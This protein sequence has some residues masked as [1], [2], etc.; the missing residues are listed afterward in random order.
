MSSYIYIINFLLIINFIYSQDWMMTITADDIDNIGAADLIY[1][2][3][4][5]TCYDGF[6]FSEDEYDLGGPPGEHTDITIYNFDWEGT[7]DQNNNVCNSVAFTVDKKSF[8]E[9][10]DLLVWNI[11][12]FANLNNNNTDIELTWILDELSND[13]EIYLYIGNS[14]YNMRSIDNIIITQEELMVNYN[15]ESGEFIPNIRVLIGGCAS[16]G[17]TTYYYDF[18]TF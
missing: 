14:S 8:H 2:G 13:Y 18:E 6:N 7:F 1:L 3:M 12:G 16:E 4:C 11:G 17:T 10:A 9:P 5:E 15:P